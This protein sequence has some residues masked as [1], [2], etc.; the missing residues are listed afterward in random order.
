MY[1]PIGKLNTVNQQPN[2]CFFCAKMK[3]NDYTEKCILLR[4]TCGEYIM[5]FFK[6]MIKQSQETNSDVFGLF[7]GVL[8]VVFRGTDD[9]QKY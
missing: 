9:V 1:Y 7:N 5:K 6:E 8:Y 3:G 2:R 4:A